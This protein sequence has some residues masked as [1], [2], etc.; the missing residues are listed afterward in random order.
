MATLRIEDRFPLVSQRGNLSGKVSIPARSAVVTE[1]W[2]TSPITGDVQEWTERTG[3]FQRNQG[4]VDMEFLN[5]REAV[6]Y[7]SLHPNDA[8]FS[9][10][11]RSAPRKRIKKKE[12]N[13]WKELFLWHVFS[14]KP[15]DNIEFSTIPTKY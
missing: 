12:G 5:A 3:N 4:M 7:S 11:P 10:K 6:S 15:E 8:S 14:I 9:Y 13:N 2:L 1:W